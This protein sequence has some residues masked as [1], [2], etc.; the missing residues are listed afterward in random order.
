MYRDFVGADPRPARAGD[1][2]RAGDR[3]SAADGSDLRQRRELRRSERTHFDIIIIGSGAGGGTMAHALASTRRADPDRRAR[4]LR[5]AGSR[6]T[7]I[8][9][10]SGRSSATGRRSGGSTSAG[11]N[12]RRTRTTA[13]AATRSSGAACSIGCAART[14]QAVEHAD[15]ISPAWPIDYETLAP[16]YDRA[17]R[18]VPRARRARRRSDRAAARAVSRIAPVPHAAGMAAIVEQLRAQGLHPSPLPLGLLRPGE[19]DGCIL[20]NTCNSF[21]CKIAREERRRGVLRPPGARSGPNVTLWTNACARAA[22]H[23]SRRAEG[24]TASRSSATARRFASTRRWSSC[25]AAPSTP[26]RCCCDRRPTRIPNGL[27]NSS[28][29]VGRRYM[30]HL[31]TMMQGFHPFRKNA[32][33]FQ[34]TVAI[35]DFYLRGPRHATTRSDRSS[36][37]DGRTASWRRPSCPWI[38]LW[39]YDAVGRARRRLAGDVGGSAAPRQPRH[40]RRRRPDPAALPAEQRRAAPDAGAETKRILRRLGF[41]IVMTHSHG[42]KNTTHQCGTL[43]FGTDPRDVGAGSVLPH[44]RRREP[45]RRRRLVLPFV[46]GG[47]SRADDR[48]AGAAG[49]PTTSRRPSSGRRSPLRESAIVQPCRHHGVELQQGGAVLLGRL[50]LSAR[51]RRRHAAG[52]RPRRSSASTRRSRA[53]RS[54]G[55]G[56]RAAACSRSSSSSRSCRPTAVPWNRVGLTH[57]SFNVQQPAEVARLPGRARASSASSQPERSPRGHSFFFVQDFDGNLIELMDLGL[58]VLRARMARPARR[59]GSS[60]A[61]CTSRTTRSQSDPGGSRRRPRRLRCGSCSASLSASCFRSRLPRRPWPRL[62]A[63]RQSPTQRRQPRR[64]HHAR[65]IRR[66]GARRSAPAAADAATPGGAWRVAR[67]MRPVNPTVTWPNHTSIVTGVTPARHGVLFNGPLDPRARRAA[68]R[69]AVARQ[70]RDGARRPRSTTLAHAR[71]PDDGAGGLGR[72]SRTRRRSRGNSA[73]GRRAGGRRDDRA[74]WSRPGSSSQADV[75]TFATRT[76]SCA[77]TSG[78]MPPVHILRRAPA[79]PAAVPPADARFD[80]APLR[81]AHAGRDEHDGASRYAGRDDRADARGHGTRGH[82]PRC[83]C[84]SDHGFKA[85][86]RQILPNA[87]LLKA[88]LLAVTDG[89]VTSD[90]GVRRARGRQCARLRH[91]AGPEGQILAQAKR[92]ARRARRDRHG[93][94]SPPTIPSYGLPTPSANDQMGALLLTAKDGYAFAGGAGD[95][96]VIDAPEGSLGAHGYVVERSRSAVAVHRIRPRDQARRDARDR[97]QRRCGADRGTPSRTGDEGCRRQGPDGHSPV[98]VSARP[99]SEPAPAG[100]R[101]SSRRPSSCRRSGVR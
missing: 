39:A 42:S 15:G 99:A 56:C 91:G 5:P 94:S 90:A 92:G 71:G 23:R 44:P 9:K 37:R 20:C 85:V 87:A 27:A 29:L 11:A 4:R 19:A 98:S 65:R 84:V 70:E 16:Y 40:R 57:I 68:A 58:H 63:S 76:S 22:A 43:C 81:S 88:G 101:Q 17:E 83:S 95:Q 13:S 35:N 14:S 25:R 1:E 86:K 48:R 21:P 41:W 97:G 96:I 32:T 82:A 8:P 100:R 38:P 52:S 18:A 26:R 62:Q 55:S 72:D 47:Q 10:R 30:A 67:G 46:G 33:V 66:L 78:R 49:S 89:K 73:S 79:E 80:A 31:A 3:G 6:R 60:G 69:R 64:H 77:T 36:R 34:K 45:L 93:R 51:R 28:G 75:D 2:P 24:S 7:G 50:R 59:H 61:G 74:R 53:A 12:C 54:A